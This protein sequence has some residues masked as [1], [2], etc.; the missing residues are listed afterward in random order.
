M[1]EARRATT[2]TVVCVGSTRLLEKPVD[3][4]C[5]AFLDALK[6]GTGPAPESE[7][8][9][10]DRLGEA[11]DEA[12]LEAERQ[13][14]VGRYRLDFALRQGER[15]LCIEADGGRWH[16]NEE[17]ERVDRDLWRD[18][19]LQA[20][21]WKTLRFWDREIERDPT[22]CVSKIREALD[23]PALFTKDRKKGYGV[24]E[25]CSKIMVLVQT[26]PQIHGARHE[27]DHSAVFA[28][29]QS[30]GVH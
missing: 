22:E 21:G 30:G 7:S 14:R 1:W 12:G 23:E 13:V 6:G 3:G 28:V 10:E 25:I 11:M 18:A 15:Q 5:R 29:V 26:A 20:A 24:L 9:L 8:G 19:C 2:Y 27:R 4:R 16:T 17:G